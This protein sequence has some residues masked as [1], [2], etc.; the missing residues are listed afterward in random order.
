MTCSAVEKASS[1]CPL[2]GSEAALVGEW[3]RSSFAAAAHAFI[4]CPWGQRRF[5][6]KLACAVL[7]QKLQFAG[8]R[9]NFITPQL[10]EK[11]GIKTDEMG[12]TYTASM[13]APGHEVAV[14][15]LIG[16]LRLH[17]Q[18]YVCHEEFFIMPL[19]GC[20]VLLGKEEDELFEKKN[21]SLL[22]IQSGV[23]TEPVPVHQQDETHSRCEYPGMEEYSACNNLGSLAADTQ[24]KGWDDWSIFNRAHI[25]TGK[26][27]DGDQ[28]SDI[29]VEL[30]TVYLGKEDCNGISYESLSSKEKLCCPE[31]KTEA[32]FPL[33]ML[34]KGHQTFTSGIK[35]QE[36]CLLAEATNKAQDAIL[37]EAELGMYAANMQSDLEILVPKSHENILHCYSATEGLDA[38]RSLRTEVLIQIQESQLMQDTSKTHLYDET[39]VK[40]HYAP[41]AQV[42]RS[43]SFK[44]AKKVAGRVCTGKISSSSATVR[45]SVILNISEE[46]PQMDFQGDGTDNSSVQSNREGLI[47]HMDGHVTEE[48]QVEE[49]TLPVTLSV[50]DSDEQ[51][52]QWFYQDQKQITHGPFCL[53]QLR[54]WAKTGIFP[55]DLV[56]W[57][58]VSVEKF[59]MLL[60][61]ALHVKATAIPSLMETQKCPLKPQDYLNPCERGDRVE[62]GSKVFSFCDEASS[63]TKSDLQ[64]VAAADTTQKEN[65]SSSMKGERII[66]RDSN[67]KLTSAL[68]R[69]LCKSTL[70]ETHETSGNVQQKQEI[71]VCRD[72]ITIRKWEKVSCTPE[73]IGTNSNW[74]PCALAK[75]NIVGEGNCKLISAQIKCRSSEVDLLAVGFFSEGE[76]N[77]NL[78]VAEAEF[79]AA[80]ASAKLTLSEKEREGNAMSAV[81]NAEFPVV[82][83]SAK[84]TLSEEE[85]ERKAMTTEGELH[86]PRPGPI[87]ENTNLASA[88][89]ALYPYS[90]SGGVQDTLAVGTQKLG[91]P[92]TISQAHQIGDIQEEEELHECEK[93]S[94]QELLEERETEREK[95]MTE[96]GWNS[97]STTKDEI[98]GQLSNEEPNLTH[99]EEKQETFTSLND[100]GWALGE[101]G[102]LDSESL[103]VTQ[104]D[105]LKAEVAALDRC[106]DELWSNFMGEITTT[107]DQWQSHISTE[108]D[109]ADWKKSAC[110][111]D[112]RRKENTASNKEDHE[113]GTWNSIWSSI[114]MLEG[115]EIPGDF[116]HTSATST[117]DNIVQGTWKAFDSACSTVLQL[118]DS[119]LERAPVLL[120][121]TMPQLR[122]GKQDVEKVLNLWE[123]GATE[124]NGDCRR[125]VS[126]LSHNGKDHCQKHAIRGHS[127]EVN[128]E[129]SSR[130]NIL[131][132]RSILEGRGHSS[133]TTLYQG[134]VESKRMYASRQVDKELSRSCPQKEAKSSRERSMSP[135]KSLKLEK[136]AGRFHARV[137]CKS[138]S[139]K[140]EHSSVN[141]N[142]SSSRSQKGGGEQKSHQSALFDGNRIRKEEFQLSHSRSGEKYPL[143]GEGGQELGRRK[144]SRVSRSRSKEK[145]PS[146]KQK[147]KGCWSISR[148]WRMD[149]ETYVHQEEEKK[150]YASLREC[151][152][153]S[154]VKNVTHSRSHYKS[155]WRCAEDKLKD[156]RS[157]YRRNDRK[158]SSG[159]EEAWEARRREKN[160]L[161][162]AHDLSFQSRRLPRYDAYLSSSR[163]A[164]NAPVYQRKQDRVSESV[165]LRKH[166]DDKRRNVDDSNEARKLLESCSGMHVRSPQQPRSFDDQG[167]TPPSSPFNNKQEAWKV[168]RGGKDNFK[169]CPNISSHARRLARSDLY[170]TPSRNADNAQ[171]YHRKQDSVSKSFD[172][173]A[174]TKCVD[175][176]RHNA[177]TRNDPR[178][179][180]TSE[181]VF[182]S[183]TE[184]PPQPPFDDRGWTPP[185]SPL[186]NQG[187]T[188][189]SELK[190]PAA[191]VPPVVTNKKRPQHPFIQSSVIAS[192]S[193]YQEGCIDLL[194]P[195]PKKLP[196]P[197]PIPA[198][199]SHLLHID[200]NE[201]CSNT[202]R[203]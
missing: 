77:A 139:G 4:A 116:P 11:M 22:E 123:G 32:K 65:R 67:G 126:C 129:G 8:A 109:S 159:E 163:S 80:H 157:S 168:R 57:R 181:G 71:K 2:I 122:S 90:T 38:D 166:L 137:E 118:P 170:T 20:D 70:L 115:K 30:G 180:L 59:C 98:L 76:G 74:E 102:V 117:K 130:D 44:M 203:I 10:A 17:I 31:E 105:A 113:D 200:D 128:L 87:D 169:R 112:V 19:E 72:P 138:F 101:S 175:G 114:S 18:G 124:T 79:P 63:D 156:G 108:N 48:G 51:A 75:E 121:S 127:V 16:K 202:D 50:N 1:A 150:S 9:A 89:Q 53:K 158:H 86:K 35:E 43:D 64:V 28:Q 107:E 201:T 58:T 144:E 120:S 27:L 21:G 176:K 49:H 171:I 197:P 41:N 83:A 40:Q 25:T 37:G 12:L 142:R 91:S 45:G 145:P 185:S 162:R 97:G 131:D 92:L 177:H 3:S 146:R 155:L 93:I 42:L 60:R 24:N 141:N 33:K 151:K 184:S 132:N 135:R 192:V 13:A 199:T 179:L 100:N 55:P 96:S 195:N 5:E 189:C 82:H 104:L 7:G 140:H 66:S 69:D 190:I 160:M 172:L 194:R 94:N 6:R 161:T 143:S 193:F 34:G 119:A 136:D 95:T 88:E 23:E 147:Y 111:L 29:S 154:D 56:I 134:R 196:S 54:K 47:C 68:C 188:P 165:D 26:Q 78:C 110:N 125:K 164:D 84:L 46:T 52:M 149:Q 73:Q 187:W 174:Q 173:C 153:A 81:A 61:T 106:R 62:G 14:T 178:R 85:R 39:N 36:S 15:P 186:K 183:K 103:W 198:E 99:T 191:R 152:S 133:K 167:W 148:G 182:L